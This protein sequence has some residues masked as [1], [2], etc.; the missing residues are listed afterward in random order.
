LPAKISRIL[1][2]WDY[3]FIALFLISVVG[4]F[5]YRASYIDGVFGKLVGCDGCFTYPLF[6]HDIIYLSVLCLLFLLSFFIRR[7]FLYIPLRIFALLGLIVYIGDV[8]TMESFFTRLYLGDVRRYGDQMGLIWRHISNTGFISHNIWIFVSLL[9]ATALVIFIPPQP[10][11]RLR[12]AFLVLMLPIAGVASGTVFQPD[13]YNHVQDWAIINVFEANQ[14]PGLSRKYSEEKTAKVIAEEQQKEKI[15][16]TGQNRKQNI[17]LLILESWSPYQSKY[18]SG[19]NDWTPKLDKLAKENTVLTQLHAGGYTTFEGLVSLLSGL[20]YVSP[21][22]RLISMKPFETAWGL[23]DTVPKILNNNGYHTAFL[24]SGNLNFANKISWLKETGFEY[25][26][27]H[28]YSEY[29]GHKRLHFDA[30]ADDVLYWRSANYIKARQIE[31]EPFFVAIENVSTHHPYTHPH[32]GEKGQEVVFRY[33]DESANNLYRQLEYQGFFDNGM[34][35]IVSD[36][37]AMVPISK[38]EM[39]HFGQAASSRIPAILINTPAQVDEISMLSH[40]SDLLPTL[41][42]YSGDEVCRSG[43]YR[44]FFDPE[45]NDERC[46]FHVR[47]DERDHIDVF[48]PQGS[49]TIV[50]NGDET[51]F[52]RYEE[53]LTKQQRKMLLEKVNSHRIIS[54]L[55]QKRFEHS[56]NKQ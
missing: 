51:G 16:W 45:N 30:V 19:I 17:V 15:C 18:W 4:A 32:T 31:E 35:I 13:S 33:M 48:C 3:A 52:L 47:G 24:T 34:M 2:L 41:I 55:R 10:V 43:A 7:F 29:K 49:G 40:Q 25:I 37:R 50:L 11:E 8:V 38:S 42:N 44:N 22:K 23:K 28:D 6:F 36:H 14:K 21:T 56:K 5:F 26:E 9:A 1:R 12:G 27:G 46:V 54:G 53:A 20:E 39:E